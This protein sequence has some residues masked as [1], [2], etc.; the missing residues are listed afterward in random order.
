MTEARNFQLIGGSQ[1]VKI[2]RP[3]VLSKNT[4]Q[5]MP[6]AP[7]GGLCH[8]RTRDVEDLPSSLNSIEIIAMLFAPISGY[9]QGSTFGQSNWTVEDVSFRKEIIEYYLMKY[10]H[11]QRNVLM[12]GS[13]MGGHLQENYDL[14]LNVHEQMDLDKM[15]RIEAILQK[16]TF[17]MM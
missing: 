9:L 8:G 6:K 3:L 1:I 11:K 4:I 13:Q 14:F 10:I 16:A 17:L 5:S 7:P 15:R 2:S 12:V